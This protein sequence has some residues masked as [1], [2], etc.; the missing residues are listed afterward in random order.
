MMAIV[1]LKRPVQLTEQQQ[2]NTLPNCVHK[3][4][5]GVENHC[6]DVCSMQAK[7]WRPQNQLHPFATL[8]EKDEILFNGVHYHRMMHWFE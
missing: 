5:P 4:N 7:R 3:A 8:Q 6:T 1:C 2:G